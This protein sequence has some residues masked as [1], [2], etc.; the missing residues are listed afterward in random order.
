MVFAF[1]TFSSH[2]FMG[3]SSFLL[4][5]MWRDAHECKTATLKVKKNNKKKKKAGLHEIRKSRL[6]TNRTPEMFSMSP[7]D[8]LL[9]SQI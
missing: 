6:C 9:Y 2:H 4:L 1:C 3:F 8:I 5:T 7:F